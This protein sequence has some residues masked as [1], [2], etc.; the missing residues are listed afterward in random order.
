MRDPHAQL[1]AI[2][3]VN[4]ERR[5]LMNKGEYR[6]FRFLEKTVADIAWGHRV[7]AQTSL[8]ELI[9]PVWKTPSKAERRDAQ[10][11]INSKRVDFAIIDRFGLLVLAVEFQGSGHY[12]HKTFLRDAV[13]REALR[14]AG[15]ELIE[16]QPDWDA[17]ALS[18]RVN[19]ALRTNGASRLVPSGA[20]GAPAS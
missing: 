20:D 15:V 16:V 17:V 19:A 14:R 9:Q 12:H 2:A 13:K 1:A 11:S 4:F 18:H 6:L 7:M 10:S 8:G 5:R 3:K